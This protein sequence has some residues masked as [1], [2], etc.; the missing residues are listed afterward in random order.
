MAERY[1]GR[2]GR[3][4][5]GDSSA[6][7][8][9]RPYKGRMRV[10]PLLLLAFALSCSKRDLHRPS[11]D[12]APPAGCVPNEGAYCT[13]SHDCAQCADAVRARG[14]GDSVLVETTVDCLD[15]S[16]G[17]PGD[18][19]LDS[20]CMRT[21]CPRER[22][23]QGQHCEGCQ[24]NLPCF[25][26]PLPDPRV[27]WGRSEGADAGISGAIE[28]CK[29]DEDCVLMVGCCSDGSVCPDLS[30]VVNRPHEEAWAA[31]HQCTSPPASRCTGGHGP[32][33]YEMPLC[34]DGMC[35][36]GLPGRVHK[37]RSSSDFL[38]S[39]SPPPQALDAGSSPSPHR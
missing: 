36:L 23:P 27:R 17:A 10:A 24:A 14:G 15:R 26:R 4:A 20:I 19:G 11:G 38:H 32:W 8:R 6:R 29:T 12:A 3:R 31:A 21:G 33:T 16:V 34:D 22:C 2:E 39:C 1:G 37:E 35:R 13:S 30:A 7:V 25:C 9:I 18:G 28:T 5:T